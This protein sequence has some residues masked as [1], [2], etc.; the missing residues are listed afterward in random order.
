MTWCNTVFYEAVTPIIKLDPQTH[1]DEVLYGK[2]WTMMTGSCSKELRQNL[3]HDEARR[4]VVAQ[5]DVLPPESCLF[6]M[7]FTMPNDQVRIGFY[8]SPSTEI[9]EW[10]DSE[11]PPWC[12]PVVE[13]PSRY[14]LLMEDDE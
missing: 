13:G 11:R 14:A 1:E 5:V 4:Q 10:G 12:Q 6:V 7:H 2:D 9:L 3:S 8:R